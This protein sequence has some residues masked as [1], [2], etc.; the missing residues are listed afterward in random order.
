LGF[1]FS[2]GIKTEKISGAFHSSKDS[3]L[4]F[5]KVPVANETVFLRI[6]GR[7]DNFTRFTEIFGKLLSG[8]SVPFDFTPGISGNFG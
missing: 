4:N 6:S 3:G 7:D 1:F 5:R 2:E 8:I